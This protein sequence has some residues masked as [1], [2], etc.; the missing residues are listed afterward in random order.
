MVGIRNIFEAGKTGGGLGKLTVEPI[1]PRQQAK[2]NQFI[3]Q[4]A[5]R[6]GITLDP[7]V[8]GGLTSPRRSA[9]RS[10]KFSMNQNGQ[11]RNGKRKLTDEEL[12]RALQFRGLI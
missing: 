8:K 10:Q 1:N 3:R 9:A 11:L 12:K 5:K 6:R 7:R 4:E 2:L